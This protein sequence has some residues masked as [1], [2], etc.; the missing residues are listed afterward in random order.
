MLKR[1]IINPKKSQR[2]TYEFLNPIKLKEALFAKCL[3][4]NPKYP[5]LIRDSH[6]G[7]MIGN[8]EYKIKSVNKWAG[9]EAKDQ[10]DAYVYLATVADEIYGDTWPMKILK[11]EVMYGKATVYGLICPSDLKVQQMCEAFKNVAAVEVN[12]AEAEP[13]TTNRSKEEKE[14]ENE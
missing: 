13:K 9:Y 7:R 8:I 14:E 4:N 5:F 6:L 10:E 2:G 1:L 12:K 11:S 3:G